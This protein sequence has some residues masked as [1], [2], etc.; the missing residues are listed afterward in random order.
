M[1]FVGNYAPWGLSPQT[2]G[3]PVI[4]KKVPHKRAPSGR[5]KHQQKQIYTER[6]HFIG[7]KAASK[8]L[9]QKFPKIISYSSFLI[10]ETLFATMEE[11]L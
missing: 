1:G 10:M 11:S 4:P 6:N 5:R 7:E 2:D 8:R 3:M 9:C